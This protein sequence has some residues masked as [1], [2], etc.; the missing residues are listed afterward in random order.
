MPMTADP[1][2]TEQSLRVR[3]GRFELNEADARLLDGGQPVPLAPR[4]FAVLCALARAPRTLVTKDALLDRIWG[5]RFVSDSVLKT[6]V[7]DLRAALQDDPKQPRYIETVSRRGYRFIAAV[8]GTANVPATPAATQPVAARPAAQP[9]PGSPSSLSSVSSISP[10]GRADGLDRLH[11][12]WQLAGTGRR[13][14][15]WLSGE[16][17]VG[18]TTLIEHFSGEVG[19]SD[20]AHGQCVEQYG[21]GEPYLP[22]LEAL[23]TLCR[24]DPALPELIRA[25]APTWLLQLPWLS[26]AAEREALRQELAGAGQARMLREMGELLDRYT[27]NRPLLLVTEDLHWSDHATVQLMDYIARR[28]TGARLLWL[29]S[30]RL[31]EIIAADHP[32]C[33]VRHELRLHGQAQ[34]IVLDAFSE[35]EVAEYVAGC[36]PALGTEQTFV[37]ALHDRTDGLPLFVANVVNDLIEN[38]QASRAK[39]SAGLGLASMA[40]PETLSGIIERYIEQ[41]APPRRALLE[42]ASVCGVEFRLSTVAQVLESDAVSLAESCAELARS[43]RWLKDLL[44]AQQNE[45]VDVGYAFRHGLYREVLYKRLGRHARVA[46]HRKVAMALEQERAHGRDVSAAELASHFELGREFM[47]A[48]R[49]YAEAAQSALLHFSPVQTISLTERAQALLQEPRGTSLPAFPARGADGKTPALTSESRERAAL[50]MTLAALQGTAAIQAHG[51]GSSEGKRAFERALALLNDVPEHPLRGLFLSAL[52]VGLC[53]RGEVDAAH[54]VAQRSEALVVASGDEMARVCAC[55]VHGMVQ[56]LHGRPRSARKWLEQGVQASEALDATTAKAVFVADPGVLIFGFLAIELLQLGFVDQGRAR[57][58]AAR[59]RA[60]ALREP[61][62]QMA[63]LWLEALFEV[64]MGNPERVADVAER[65]RRLA[66]EYAQPEGRAAHLWFRGWAEAHLGDPRTG[67]RLIRE[68]WE[69]AARLGMRS[70]AGE[71]LGYAAEALARAGDWAAARRQLDEAMQCAGAIG[72]RKYLT[73]LLLLDARIA[74]ALGEPERARAS[75]QRA[76]EE[77]RAQE[78]VWLQLVALSARCERRDATDDDLAALSL[79]VDQLTEGLDTAPVARARALLSRAE[80]A[81]KN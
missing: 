49:Y 67:Y 70:D 41:L 8:N 14:I 7:S 74:E 66:E 1:S 69:A 50:E 39:S 77:A 21:A 46:L 78:A 3:F 76:I 64:R 12:A 19:E 28:R 5:H 13:Q 42:A 35:K 44:P 25:V 55:L 10:I 75:M 26:T 81:L 31:T 6:T 40:I 24:R 29:A 16:A 71:T 51:I 56:H 11:K 15:V 27:E 79:V 80:V 65:L 58:R 60:L 17:G 2:L 68:G 32:L 33:A 9:S 52:G 45:L 36:I 37:R 62:P 53:I 4:P 34:E 43:H 72:D 38:G 59:A 23:T 22:I 61:S 47:P 30:F 48:L 57:L 20:C 54:A 73:Q 63:A 18:K